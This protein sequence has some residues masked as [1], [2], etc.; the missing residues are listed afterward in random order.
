VGGAGRALMRGVWGTDEYRGEAPVHLAGRVP[1]PGRE[2]A[3][4]VARGLCRQSIM[5]G[6][7]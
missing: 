4:L 7:D 3:Q 6:L 2:T 1:S 5:T